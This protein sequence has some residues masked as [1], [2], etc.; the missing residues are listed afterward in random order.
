M[1]GADRCTPTC[2]LQLLSS[3]FL[4]YW[5]GLWSI[6]F[7]FHTDSNSPLCNGMDGIVTIV[8]EVDQKK[9]LEQGQQSRPRE[10]QLS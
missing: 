5:Q 10:N 1:Q 8:I 7:F 9:I 6:F 4:P 3:V 2:L